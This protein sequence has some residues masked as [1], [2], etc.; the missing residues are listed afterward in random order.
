VVSLSLNGPSCAPSSIRGEGVNTYVWPTRAAAQTWDVETMVGS[1]VGEI[2]Q[3]GYVFGVSSKDPLLAAVSSALYP[4]RTDA[5]D[6]IG[7]HLRGRC[8]N[9]G[10][11]TS[12]CLVER[13]P[14]GYSGVRLIRRTNQPLPC[15]AAGSDFTHDAVECHSM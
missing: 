10:A 12:R 7:L 4:S 9:G 8:E 14:A 11:A 6:A 1:K 2:K 13:A 15:P 5:M 3:Q